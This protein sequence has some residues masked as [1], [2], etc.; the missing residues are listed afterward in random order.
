MRQPG[1]ALVTPGDIRDIPATAVVDPLG[2]ANIPGCKCFVF[3]P[4][5]DEI[6]DDQQGASKDGR[7]DGDRVGRV[8]GSPVGERSQRHDELLAEDEHQIDEP[9]RL[10]VEETRTAELRDAQSLALERDAEVIDVE[11]NAAVEDSSKEIEYEDFPRHEKSDPISL[12]GPERDSLRTR[13]LVLCPR[14]PG[15]ET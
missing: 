7:Q 11:R 8:N 15:P 12:R 13:E 2:R 5:W 9:A 1:R 10:A 6:V 14:L 4:I 3:P